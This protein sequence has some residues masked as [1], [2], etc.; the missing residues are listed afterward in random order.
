MKTVERSG[1]RKAPGHPNR[2]GHFKTER[3]SRFDALA[4]PGLI[5]AK[6]AQIG[7]MTTLHDQ[8]G[9]R[10]YLT[11]AERDAFLEAAT[12][13][14]VREMRTFCATLAYTGCR[15]SEALALTADRI[16]LKDGTIVI[17]S[18]K[19]R[20]TG[21]YRPIPVPPALLDMLNLV[22]DIRAA[23]K[24]RDR[25]ETVRL[26]TWS[27]TKGWYCR[28]CGDEGCKDRRSTRHTKR[29]PARLRHQSDQLRGA[30]KHVAAVV[31]SRPTFNH[32]HI[33]RCHGSGETAA[34]AAHVVMIKLRRHCRARYRRT[35][36]RR[37]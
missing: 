22:H 21:I 9:H 10:K 4:G 37:R 29:A 27:R 3:G 15:I 30:A 28:L 25:G 12:D 20:Q 16:D 6:A 8:H 17:E 13:A 33:C 1:S 34:G 36:A 7:S 5:R 35:A 24:R 2:S 14:E 31:R 19:K 26:W 11:L 23:H 18:A 32:V